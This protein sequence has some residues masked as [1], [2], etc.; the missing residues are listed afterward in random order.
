MDGQAKEIKCEDYPNG[1]Y[2]CKY[3]I[4]G[5]NNE[6]E[7]VLCMLTKKEIA[8]AEQQMP[9]GKGPDIAS[10]LHEDIEARARLGE[11]KYGERL[12]AFNGRDP[13][14]DAYQE[15]LDLAFYLRQLLV[16]REAGLKTF[17]NFKKARD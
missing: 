1:C 4:V 16:E 10:L 3:A 17:N 12:K 2:C 6:E 5:G 15:V 9:E 11:R 7:V 8:V 14:L 13:L